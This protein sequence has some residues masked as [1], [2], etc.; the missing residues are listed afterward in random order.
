MTDL[1]LLPEVNININVSFQLMFTYKTRTSG[2]VSTLK[3]GLAKARIVAFHVGK[4]IILRHFGAKHSPYDSFYP[5]KVLLF[6][7][8][9]RQVTDK[10]KLSDRI[11]SYMYLIYAR[12]FS[13]VCSRQAA[14]LPT[15]MRLC[16]DTSGMV[17]YSNARI[18][19][20]EQGGGGGGGGRRVSERAPRPG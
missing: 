14:H 15:F 5:V 3:G 12:T 18:N 6:T 7:P 11:F 2:F 13:S 9:P 10:Q 1:L 19:P 16:L 20:N 8:P 17:P 4:S